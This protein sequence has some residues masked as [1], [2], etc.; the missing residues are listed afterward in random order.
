MTKT[1]EVRARHWAGGWELHIDQVGVTQVR[2][3]DKAERQ[4][5]DYLETLL[6]LDVSDTVVN[7]NPDLGGLEE[8]VREAKERS[9]AAEAA[10]RAAAQQARLVAVDLRK[11]GLSVS[12]T[13]T[14]MGVSRGRVSQLVKTRTAQPPKVASRAAPR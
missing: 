12:D 2:T 5:R 3:L 6:G 4:V 9:R 1:Y 11:R 8:N 10:Q 7:I 14:V 13:A